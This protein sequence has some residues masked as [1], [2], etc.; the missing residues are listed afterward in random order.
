MKLECYWRS[1]R[2]GDKENVAFQ[3]KE[4]ENVRNGNDN[5]NIKTSG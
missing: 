2:K 1:N 4:T 5:R 3:K